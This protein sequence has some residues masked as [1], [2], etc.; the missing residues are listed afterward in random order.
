MNKNWYDKLNKSSLTPPLKK[1]SSMA[2]TLY[3]F[4]YFLLMIFNPEC[5]FIYDLKFFPS[6]NYI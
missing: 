5:Q 4:S 3:K 1:K 6:P 2:I